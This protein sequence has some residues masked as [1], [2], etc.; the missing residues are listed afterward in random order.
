MAVHAIAAAD[1][2]ARLDQFDAVID[3]RSESEFAEDHL[4]G[5]VN[6]PSLDDAALDRKV[7]ERLEEERAE[8]E[9]SRGHRRVAPASARRA[10]E[11]TSRSRSSDARAVR[12]R[13][14]P[15]LHFH[16]DDSVDRGERID[17]LLRDT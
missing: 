11:S 16:Y 15:E 10:G 12:M 7:R 9:E 5:A 1:A 2:I 13:H 8:T 4:P 6:W 17:Q 3:A 14:V